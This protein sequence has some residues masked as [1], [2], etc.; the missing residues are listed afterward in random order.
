MI[1]AIVA[2]TAG[3]TA[4]GAGPGGR[5]AGAN[6]ARLTLD[7]GPVRTAQVVTLPGTSYRAFALPVSEGE[8]IA[9]VDTFDGQGNRLTHEA[10]WD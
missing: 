5:A 7:G 1:E 4:A 3:A 10:Y 6:G 8:T 2:I 9:S